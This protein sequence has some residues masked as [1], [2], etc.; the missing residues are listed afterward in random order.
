MRGP[1]LYTNS[2]QDVHLALDWLV[3]FCS[4]IDKGDK[5]IEDGL[6]SELRGLI[7]AHRDSRKAHFL[8]YILLVHFLPTCLLCFFQIAFDLGG[9]AV[10]L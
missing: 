2:H 1:H 9:S 8:H 10:H 6:D 7:S 4:R 3:R 5:L